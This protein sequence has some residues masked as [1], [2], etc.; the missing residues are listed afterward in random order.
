[1]T[2]DMILQYLGIVTDT[3]KIQDLSFT[4]NIILPDANY[5]LI[6][7]NGVIMYEKDEHMEEAD[8]TW[9][10]NKLGLFGIVKKNED[11]VKKNITQEGDTTLLEKLMSGVTGFNDARFFNIIEPKPETASSVEAAAKDNKAADKTNEEL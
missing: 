2:S 9:T 11:A 1:M 6:V 5:I 8:A 10:T 3:M 4:A 7:R